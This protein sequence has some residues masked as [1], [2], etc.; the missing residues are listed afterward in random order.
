MLGWWLACVAVEPEP[1]D[2]PAVSPSLTGQELFEFACARCHGAD[3]R[4]GNGGPDLLERA[5]DEAAI[6]DAVLDG[7]GF[8]EPVPLDEAQAERVAGYVLELLSGT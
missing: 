5:V 8:M 1:Q 2:E 7:I 3:A 4:G 6:V